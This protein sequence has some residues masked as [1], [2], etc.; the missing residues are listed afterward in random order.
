MYFDDIQSDSKIYA[1]DETKKIK[2]QRSSYLTHRFHE[3]SSLSDIHLESGPYELPPDLECDV[4][5]AAGDIGVGTQG[6]EW[7]K[8]LDKPVVYVA[9][10]HE[11]WSEQK[12]PIDMFQVQRDIRNAAEGS[13]VHY[14]ENETVT[15]DGVQFIGATL[16]TNLGSCGYDLSPGLIREARFMG[17]SCIY[18]KEFY[19]NQSLNSRFFYLIERYIK[20]LREEADL[21]DWIRENAIKRSN[22]GEWHPLVSLILHN[23]SLSFI[24]NHTKFDP[25]N[26]DQKRIVV[27]H[28]HPSYRSLLEA[29]VLSEEQLSPRS[30]LDYVSGR[31][32]SGFLQAAAYA[33]D[34][35]LLQPCM[36]GSS[37]LDR[38]SN[39]ISH[40]LCGHLHHHL[41]YYQTGVRISCNPRGRY[42]GPMTQ[43]S[44]L[45]Y[46]LFGY[47]GYAYTKDDWLA[48]TEKRVPNDLHSHA[49]A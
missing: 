43:K 6:L 42:C 4:I 30:R 33:S 18:C 39:Q 5:V 16:W 20:D 34:L 27:T 36:V 40:W 15:I 25:E 13:N 22:S 17:D 12:N 24:T 8:T 37:K 45:A 35:E 7:L 41:D 48:E 11:Y 44:R 49:L 2:R 23:I 19:D 47:P 26:P 28:H 46:A 32:H 9:G 21:K 1:V 10:N 31:E 14:L 29:K 38:F 3:N